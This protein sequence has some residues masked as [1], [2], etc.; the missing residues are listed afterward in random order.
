MEK[1]YALNLADDGRILSVTYSK[2]APE[3][4]PRVAELPDGDLYEY[5]YVNGVFVHDPLPKEEEEEAEPLEVQVAEL[6]EALDLL[7]SGV[8][9]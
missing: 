1:T 2:Y 7:L 6:R 4:A 3:D 5:R 8:T 9:E